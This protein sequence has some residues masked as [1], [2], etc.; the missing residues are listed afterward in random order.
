MIKNKRSAS[1]VIRGSRA[2]EIREALKKIPLK[3]RLDRKW[4]D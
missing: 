1:Y 4:E 2:Y 3:F